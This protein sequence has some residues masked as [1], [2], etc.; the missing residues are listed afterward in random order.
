M[1]AIKKSTL[2]ALA[3]ITR[4]Y[5]KTGDVDIL[6]ARIETAKKLAAQAY[7]RDNAWTAFVDFAESTCGV[8]ALRDNCTNEVFCELFRA[9]KFEVLDE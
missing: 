4:K 9:L 1:K 7:G 3:R 2:F 6:S 5:A 8:Y